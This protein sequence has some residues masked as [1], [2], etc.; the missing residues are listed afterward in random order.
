MADIL[1]PRRCKSG[2][3]LIEVLIAL[4]VFSVLG[5]TVVSRVG[6]VVTQLYGMERR[7][8]AHWVADN[9]MARVKLSQ[10]TKTEPLATG[11]ERERVFMAGREWRVDMEVQDTSHPWLRRVDVEV[12]EMQAT[13]AVGPLETIVSF[14]G[15]Y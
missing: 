11:R 9:Q 10:R 14:V 3:T 4:L 13:G 15:R 5:F 8:V 2:F 1:R 6:D 7:A 12:Y